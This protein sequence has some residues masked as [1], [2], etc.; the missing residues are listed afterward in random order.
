MSGRSAVFLACNREFMGAVVTEA[1]LVRVRGFAHFHRE[2]FD[3]THALGRAAAARCGDRRSLITIARGASALV[4]NHAAPRITP[5]ILDAL[6]ELRFISELERD[7]FAFRINVEAARERGIRP[8]DTTD[9]SS[10]CVAEWA[11]AKTLIG[12]RNSG[13][14]FRRLFCSLTSWGTGTIILTDRWTIIQIAFTWA[15]G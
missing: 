1:Q 13:S 7:L 12:L 9:R 8:N 11:L 2:A 10:Y 4:I 15:A 5:Q 6:P 14:L 3:M